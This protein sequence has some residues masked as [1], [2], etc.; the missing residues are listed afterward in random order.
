[1]AEVGV[2]VLLSAVAQVVA[3]PVWAAGVW[4]IGR[5][6]TRSDRA[7]GFRAVAR[8]LAF[9]QTPVAFVVVIPI[10]AGRLLARSRRP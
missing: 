1:M 3:W 8:V 6:M 9:A 5:R 4:A 7:P 2:M 10:M